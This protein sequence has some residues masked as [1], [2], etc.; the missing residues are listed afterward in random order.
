M[1]DPDSVVPNRR[2]CAFARVWHGYPA[3]LKP[4]IL[5][6][7]RIWRYWHAQQW[8]RKPLLLCRW[9]RLRFRSETKEERLPSSIEIRRLL[10]L[11]ARPKRRDNFEWTSDRL[12]FREDRCRSIR[13]PNRDLKHSFR[14][15]TAWNQRAPSNQPPTTT[16][17]NS[18][19]GRRS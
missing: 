8:Q 13:R 12:N 16:R 9:K 2:Q 18:P 1:S 11:V 4:T 10:P 15:D 17:R 3:R 5:S 14:R 19:H 7:A 6:N